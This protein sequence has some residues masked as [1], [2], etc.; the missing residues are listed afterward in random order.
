MPV[1]PEI[2]GHSRYCGGCF[3]EHVEPE[4]SLYEEI[5]ERAE[6]VFVFFKTQKKGIPLLKKERHREFV[7]ACPDRDETILRLAYLSASKG[8][9]AVI[10]VE[11]TAKK[12]RNEAYQTSI[13]SGSGIPAQVDSS[14]I[15]EDDLA[16]EI[17]R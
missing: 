1:I 5:L 8:F 4:L 2:L 11:V 12:V 16:D 13:W 6:K 14:R 15:Y 3:A 7:E 9:N 17:Y 10:D